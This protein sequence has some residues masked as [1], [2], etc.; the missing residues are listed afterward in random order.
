MRRSF[1]S[2]ALGLVLAAAPVLAAD[3]YVLQ[4]AKWGAKQDRAVAAAGGT[5][6]WKH[7]ASG[8]GVATSSSRTFLKKVQAS[9]SFQQVAKDVAVQWQQPTFEQADVT[10]YDE[11]FYYPYQWSLW[12][13]DAEGAWNN[14]CTGAGVR[15]AVIDG[16]I[17][18]IHPDIEPNL[19]KSCSASFVP[20]L[21]Y[22]EDTD[23]D[24][25]WHGTHVAGIVAA[26]DNEFGVIGVAPDA[27]LVGIKALDNGS[28]SFGQIIGAILY[29][30]DP[31]SFGRPE[32]AR[33]DIIN[34]SL[35]A[36]FPKSAVGGGP[37]NAAMAKAVNFAGSK[38]VL[39]I[40]ATGN[41]GVD[42]G[43]AYNWVVVPAQSGS[44][45]AVSATGPEGYYYG[46]TD[47]RR[48]ASYSNYGEGV[49]SVAAPGG[50]FTLAYEGDANYVFDMV[51]STC[52][53]DT[54]PPTFSFCFAAGTSMAAPHAAGVA[55]LILGANPG[56]DKGTLKEMLLDAT[57]DEG[58]SGNDEFYGKGYVN[59]YKACVGP[60]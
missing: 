6:V 54:T 51:I 5:I 60:Y 57:D 22:N 55:A 47:F 4:A 7:G 24:E 29:A 8:I 27:T 35:G 53:G 9:K 58:K 26:A 48:P 44:G 31:A 41:D 28:G 50:D 46:A 39:V 30:A 59:A 36:L 16:G 19:D 49:V 23:V 56:I 34:M 12:S 21:D 38:G 15:V 10:P 40:S 11:D 2:L 43:Q 14:G 20:G 32:C 25:F 17:Y 3:S 37:L 13:I 45:L 42:L 33:A 1:V 52:R 18:D